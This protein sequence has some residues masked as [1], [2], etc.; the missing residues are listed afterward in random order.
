MQGLMMDTPLL[1]SSI[2]EHA[3]RNHGGREIVSDTSTLEDFTA[4]VDWGDGEPN[5]TV[6]LGGLIVE[7]DGNVEHTYSAAGSYD[8]TATANAANG[9]ASSAVT[10]QIS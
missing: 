5:T 1:V 9:T 4:V 10:V 3:A 7:A 8:I 2:A 6:P